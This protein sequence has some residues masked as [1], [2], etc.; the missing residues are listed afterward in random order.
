[1]HRSERMGPV[2]Q[3]LVVSMPWTAIGFGC[4]GNKPVLIEVPGGEVTCS[5]AVQLMHE[6][7]HA[8]ECVRAHAW[9]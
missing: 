9:V 7:G 4:H 5:P 2:G 6:P 8:R 3:M 1:M